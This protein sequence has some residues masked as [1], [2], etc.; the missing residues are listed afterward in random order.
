[1]A[2]EHF[3]GLMS[4]TS[5]DGVDASLMT[6][7]ADGGRM[8][9]S[10]SLPFEQDLQSRLRALANDSRLSLDVL[11]DSERSLTDFYAKTVGGLLENSPVSRQQITAIGCHGQT[12]RHLPAQGFS[13]QIGNPALLAA[14]TGLPVVADFRSGDL[15]RGGQGAPLAPAFHQAFF[16]DPQERRLVVN[17]GGIA[18]VSCLTPGEAVRGWDTGPGNTLLDAWYRRHHKKG[19]WDEGGQWAASGMICDDLLSRLLDDPYFRAAGP[20][21]T[22]P[23]HFNLDWLE[24]QAGQLLDQQASADIQATLLEL[25]VRPIAAAAAGMEAD[26][27][28]ISG[29][30]AFNRQLLNRLAE[31]LGGIRLVTSDAFGITT[32]QVE[33]AGFAWLARERWHERTVPLRAVTGAR[34]DGLAGAVWLP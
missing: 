31:L 18:N 32:D 15:A 28:L 33:S 4:G 26:Q 1:V 25:T 24:A 8:L 6:F 11:A 23:E 2:E 10:V 22:G 16:A 21:S 29:G 5:L 13:W 30:G 34:S 3:I 20:K 27:V 9:N 14:T 17:I 12:I 19:Q 7:S